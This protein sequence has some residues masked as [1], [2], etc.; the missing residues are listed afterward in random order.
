[1]PGRGLERFCFIERGY[2]WQRQKRSKAHSSMSKIQ[3]VITDSRL[4]LKRAL[5]ATYIPKDMDPLPERIILNK[6]KE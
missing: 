3:N 1:M 6:V 2:L 5:L 4:R